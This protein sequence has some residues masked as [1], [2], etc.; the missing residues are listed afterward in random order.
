MLEEGFMRG[1]GGIVECKQEGYLRWSDLWGRSHQENFLDLRGNEEKS[2]GLVN[3][4]RKD[5]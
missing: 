4:D 2:W 5:I 3:I 1:S